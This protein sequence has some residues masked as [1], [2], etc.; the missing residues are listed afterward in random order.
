ML[1]TLETRGDDMNF[2]RPINAQKDSRGKK[3]PLR[4]VLWWCILL[5]VLLLALVLAAPSLLSTAGVRNLLLATLNRQI[6]PATLS[7]DTWKLCWTQPQTVTNITYTDPAA[8]LTA[9]LPSLTLNPLLELLPIG[10]I[11]AEIALQSPTLHWDAAA[12]TAQTP[13]ATTVTTEPTPPADTAAEAPAILLPAWD[14]ALRLNITDATFISP[15]LPQP[16][17][18]RGDFSLHLPARDAPI[19]LTLSSQ[20]LAAPLTATA[21]LCPLTEL[22]AAGVSPRALQEARVQFDAPWAQLMF[23]ATATEKSLPEASLDFTLEAGRAFSRLRPLN[24][25]PQ[26]L[27]SVSGAITLKAALAPTGN[28]NFQTTC[29]LTG[30][31]FAFAYDGKTLLC[32]PSIAANLLLIPEHPLESRLHQLDVRLPGV[33]VRGAGTLNDCTLEASFDTAAFWTTFAPFIGAYPLLQPFTATLSAALHHQSLELSAALH[34]RQRAIGSLSLKADGLDVETQSVQALKL[35]SRWSLEDLLAIVS[36]LP[37]TSVAKGEL[38]ANL[39][40]K[41][42]LDHLEAEALFACQNATLRSTAW[43]IV[44]PQLAK[45]EAKFVLEN[46][47]LALRSLALS[48]PIATLSGEAD[49]QFS[50]SPTGAFRITGELLPETLFKTWRNWGKDE[51]PFQMNGTL[52]CALSGTLQ[53]QTLNTAAT[54]QTEDLQFHPKNSDP[55][56]LPFKLQLNADLQKQGATLKHCAFTMQGL[57]VNGKGALALPDGQL[58][59]TGEWTPDF[60]TL[61]TT[62]PPLAKHRGT[63]AV[64]GR[65]SNAFTFETPLFH[66]L[67]GIVNYGRGSTTLAF[68]TLTCPGLDVPGGQLAFTLAEGV[69]ALDGELAVN[70]G[71]LFLHPRLSYEGTDPVLTWKPDRPVLEKVQLTPKLF[72]TTI[73]ALS[74]LLIG[75]ASPSGALSLTCNALRLPLTPQMKTAVTAAFTLQTENCQLHPNGAVRD[76]FNVISERPSALRL[77]DQ[78]F[79]VNIDQG[80]LVTDPIHFRIEALKVSCEGKTN[81]AT[82]TIDYR[83]T[84]PLTAQL[85]GRSLAKHAKPG[86]TVVLPVHGTMTQPK[87]DTTPLVNAVSSVAVERAKQKLSEKLDKALQ[88]R[89]RKAA[90][91]PESGRSPEKASPEDA[92]EEALRNLFRH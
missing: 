6:A 84:I 30:K 8:G 34:H 27:N 33:S 82:Q 66:G 47:R 51:T 46:D 45:G 50:P 12:L 83:V 18:Q 65:H 54:V 62:L 58:A 57:E 63:F 72:D 40:A 55:L 90:K 44:A 14:I 41:G 73:A 23:Q 20:C 59:L 26:A 85:L 87:V 36:H 39:A 9:T 88:K 42:S 61:F 71:K 91:P 79:R 56:P 29:S 80:L 3:H 89:A 4:P 25:L 16:I 2:L 11:R 1:Q 60:D 52:S 28:G 35:N 32:E 10:K 69:A 13:P 5:P 37:K 86:Q 7:V 64:S 48:S 43:T 67:P 31:E 70:N 19:Q 38:Y 49:V 68:D 15:Q 24:L 74:P 92:L 75:S 21:T 22:V 76:I 77:D 53:A 81:L 17:L 78:T